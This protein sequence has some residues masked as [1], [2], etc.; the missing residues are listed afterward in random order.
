[1]E[2]ILTTTRGSVREAITTIRA[3]AADYLQKP[4]DFPH[5]LKQVVALAA[6]R[7]GRAPLDARHSG[8]RQP[9]AADRHRRPIDGDGAACAARIAA[10]ADSDTTV[11]ITGESGTGKELVARAMH[12]ESRRRAVRW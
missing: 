3:A 7:G 12:R 4:L 8:P 10:I 9:G 5:L 2:V 1:M 11:M 6:G